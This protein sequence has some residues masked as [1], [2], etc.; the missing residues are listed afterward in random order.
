M[1]KA[2]LDRD[3]LYQKYIV[4]NLSWIELANLANCSP[5]FIGKMVKLYDLKKDQDKIKEAR[6]KTNL[7]NFGVENV[8]KSQEVK[9]RKRQAI[10]KK[11]GVENQ[12]QNEAVKEK[13]KKTNL[14]K[15]GVENPSQSQAVKNKKIETTLK[16]FGV[17]SPLQN[18]EV[19]E[20]V[21][22]TVKEKY[23]TD[24][25]LKNEEVKKKAEKT[26]MERY[27]V[28]NPFQADEIKKKIQ[29]TQS[30]NGT[31]SIIY[32][33]TPA[34]WAVEYEISD[35]AIY[36]W[37]SLNKDFTEAQFLDFCQNY[38]HKISDIENLVSNSLD[39]TFWNKHPSKKINYKPDFKISDDIY[40]NADGLYWHSEEKVPSDYHF[41]MR[42]KYEEVGLRIFQFRADEIFFKM[43]IV[44][45]MVNN[46][47]NKSEVK[48]GAR[49]TIL[50][51]V[52]SGLAKEFLDKNHIKGYKTAKHL[53]LFYKDEL[54]S[55]MSY[56]TQQNSYV[57]IER[58]CSKVNSNIIGGF[59]KLIKEI[60]V[61]TKSLP[62]HYWV[63]LRYGTGKFLLN[64]EFVLDREAQGWEWTDYKFTYNRLKCRANM[65]DR[66]LSEKDHAKE[67]GLHKIWDAGQRLYIWNQKNI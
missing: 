8:A 15:Y 13:I 45:S 54:I 3:W 46:A 27:G 55:I 36:K 59:S 25:S 58:F 7:K 23:G 4:E 31:I 21:A 19:L 14:A 61:L 62:I 2:N 64:H 26:L 16:N 42:Q 57:K 66:K 51:E 1:K 47:L 17:E 52:D 50:K 28:T 41:M 48:I 63:D 56:K 53:G 12:F 22:K 24:C 60:K 10:V 49:K 11:Y 5:Y 37:L 33:K 30:K 32:G 67:L 9:E 20:K 29:E 44:K 39:I 34:A 65:D 38:E 43:P 35:M 6:E 40:L 18:K